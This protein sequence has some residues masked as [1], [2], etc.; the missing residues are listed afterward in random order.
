[1]QVLWLY[2]AAKIVFFNFHLFIILL[3]IR[4][5]R[6]IIISWLDLDS[7]LGVIRVNAVTFLLMFFFLFLFVVDVVRICY[8]SVWRAALDSIDWA[9]ELFNIEQC[10]LRIPISLLIQFIVVWRIFIIFVYY[11]NCYFDWIMRK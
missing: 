5:D 1:M 7:F 6:I 9:G 2:S 8:H 10:W 11:N 4:L 3:S